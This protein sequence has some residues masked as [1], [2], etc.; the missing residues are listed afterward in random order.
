MRHA[1]A[2]PLDSALKVR[3]RLADRVVHLTA[4]LVADQDLV[5]PGIEV[6]G[7]SGGAGRHVSE[8]QSVQ[9][10]GVFPLVDG[11]FCREPALFRLVHGPGVM[12]DQAYQAR[13]RSQRFKVPSTVEGMEPGVT[14]SGRVADV[15]QPRSSNEKIPVSLGHSRG[16]LASPSSHG[17][18]MQPAIPERRKQGLSEFRRSLG[19]VQCRRHG[20]RKSV[21]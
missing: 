18:S 1:V 14:Q 21:V 7:L 13:R 3:P 9:D 15:M 10:R 5:N 17:L 2:G 6:E 19:R 4:R 11:K 20:D 8:D 16:N 12:G